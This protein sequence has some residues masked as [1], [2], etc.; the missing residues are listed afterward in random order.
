MRVD[1]V[2]VPTL[3]F[4]GFLQRNVIFTACEDK[5]TDCDFASNNKT[6]IR[7]QVNYQALGPQ[8]SPVV[9]GTL[10]QSWSVNG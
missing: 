1:C 9:T 2:N 6:L 10:V 3:T 7:A 5:G 4:S 8:S